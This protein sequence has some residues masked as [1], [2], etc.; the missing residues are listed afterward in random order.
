MKVDKGEIRDGVEWY[1]VTEDD[2]AVLEEC[3]CARCGSSC[4]FLRCGAP[5]CDRGYIEDE[6]RDDNRM[7]CDYCWGK[8]GAWHCLSSPAHCKANPL[9]GREAIESTAMNPEAWTDGL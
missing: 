1:R 8:G 9:P 3:Q 7:I 4:E 5:G 6:D 2:G